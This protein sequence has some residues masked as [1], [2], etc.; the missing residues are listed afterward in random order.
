VQADRVNSLVRSD[1]AE[2]GARRVKGKLQSTLALYVLKF[3]SELFF[4][5]D[6]GTTEASRPYLR[7]RL[8]YR[9][10]SFSR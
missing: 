6:A 4:V 3:D 5:G 1:F 8:R 9:T 7:C 2:L 10:G